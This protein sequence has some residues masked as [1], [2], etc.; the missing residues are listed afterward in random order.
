MLSHISASERTCMFS[1]FHHLLQRHGLR[2]ARCAKP[3]SAVLYSA[4]R[5]RKLAKPVPEHFRRDYNHFVFLAAVN[6]DFCVNHFRQHYHVACP[7]PDELVLPFEFPDI[8]QKLFLFLS[9][10]SFYFSSFPLWQEF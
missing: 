1:Y 5:Q 3:R 10:A 7:C 9:E 4:P 8:F 2:R 6:A